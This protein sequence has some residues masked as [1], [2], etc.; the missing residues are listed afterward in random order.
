MATEDEI[1]ETEATPALQ[2]DFID[3]IESYPYVTTLLQDLAAWLRGEGD[4][5]GAVIID[6]A[7]AQM[8]T[9]EAEETADEDEDEE[10]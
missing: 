2:G 10:D 8:A 9:L 6:K 7:W 5:S 1:I 4:E 3:L